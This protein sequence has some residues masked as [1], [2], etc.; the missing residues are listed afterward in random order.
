MRVIYLIILFFS[1]TKVNATNL[2]SLFSI[3]INFYQSEQYDSSIIF[4]DSIVT[5]GY[6]SE[7]IYF[8]LGNSH[9]LK[10][11]IPKSI[12]NFEKSLAINPNNIEAKSNLE[13]T[14]KRILL[15][16]KLPQLFTY[17][18]WGGFISVFSLRIWSIITL[19]FVWFSCLSIYLFFNNKTKR[20]FNTIIILLAMSFVS[21]CAL[22]SKINS[23]QSTYGILS[24]KT[25][26]YKQANTSSITNEIGQG[27]KAL[28]LLEKED[29]VFVQFSNGLEGWLKIESLL[30]I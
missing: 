28:I 6:E 22:K 10:G 20:M 12:L 9:Y 30:I 3:A 19:T 24:E 2:D 17:K 11:N 26:L 15:L 13:I 29:W 4:Y 25:E 16:E 18:W 21:G 8:N 1:L 27:N 7:E 23:N 14:Q 5:L